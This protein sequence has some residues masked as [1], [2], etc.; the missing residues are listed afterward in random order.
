VDIFGHTPLDDAIASGHAACISLLQAIGAPL[1]TD[2][3]M[4]A[5]HLLAAEHVQR[6]LAELEAR[7]F[8][9]LVDALPER[10]CAREIV[11]VTAAI[12]SFVQVFAVSLFSLLVHVFSRARSFSTTL[13]S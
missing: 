9:R 8:D 3:D 4:Q 5:E 7:T 12:D 10:L 1:G 13:L 6:E 2:E 11:G